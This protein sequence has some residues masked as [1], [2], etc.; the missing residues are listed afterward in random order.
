MVANQTDWQR[1]TCSVVCQGYNKW[2]I[3]PNSFSLQG[4]LTHYLTIFE[5]NKGVAEHPDKPPGQTPRQMSIG[6]YKFY[7]GKRIRNESSVLLNIKFFN[8]IMCEW[9][10]NQDAYIQDPCIRDCCFY[11]SWC[12][13]RGRQE[14]WGGCCRWRQ[15]G[16][17]RGCG[18]QVSCRWRQSGDWGQCGPQVSCRWM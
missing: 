13:G 12:G 15:S 10:V 5:P 18:P 1:N 7:Q 16:D 6:L 9:N 4:T 14:E 17:W 3:D 11:L 8:A 2:F